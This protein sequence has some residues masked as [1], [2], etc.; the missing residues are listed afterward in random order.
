MMDRKKLKLA[1]P[2]PLLE[3]SFDQTLVSQY[4]QTHTSSTVTK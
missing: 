1:N 4:Q 3:Q 2:S